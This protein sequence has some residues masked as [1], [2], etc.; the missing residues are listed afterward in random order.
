MHT[1]STL[2][3]VCL[4]AISIALAGTLA[5]ASSQN[6]DDRTKSDDSERPKIVLKAQPIIAL[7]PARVVLT[8][9]LRGGSD[10]FEEYY[11]PAVVWEWGDDTRSEF[12][13]DCAPFESDKSTIKRR[14]TIE[15]T[16]KVPGVYH[17]LFHLKRSDKSLATSSTDIQV[18]P[19]L[20]QFE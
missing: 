2:C 14:F 15:H 7:A 12:G 5:A 4:G 19:G 6:K 9:E 10:H 13:N 8:V 3:V 16:Y 20:G 1:S 18:R 11:C 17:V